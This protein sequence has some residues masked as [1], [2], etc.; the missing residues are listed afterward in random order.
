M[1]V[2]REE[3]CR[4][5]TLLLPNSSTSPADWCYAPINV[6]PVGGGGSWEKDLTV[7][8]FLKCELWTILV[9]FLAKFYWYS[10]LFNH[11]QMPCGGGVWTEWKPQLSS[12]APPILCLASPVPPCKLALIGALYKFYSVRSFVHPGSFNVVNRQ[13]KLDDVKFFCCAQFL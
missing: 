2:A 6:K 10:E 7:I 5:C 9:D 8:V 12:N 3:C 13:D 1:I 4:V 11:P